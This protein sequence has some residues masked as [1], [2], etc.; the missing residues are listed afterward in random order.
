MDAEEATLAQVWEKSAKVS[1]LSFPA[2]YGHSVC[3]GKE[4]PMT[5]KI[6]QHL[7]WIVCWWWNLSD[8]WFRLAE[9]TR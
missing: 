4:N 6:L 8:W 9:Q 5:F 3:V 2:H 1:L 7:R